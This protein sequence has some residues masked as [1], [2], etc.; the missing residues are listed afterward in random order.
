MSGAAS[1]LIPSKDRLALELERLYGRFAGANTEIADTSI[2][3]VMVLE[4]ARPADWALLAPVWHSFVNDWKLPPPAIAVNGVDGIQ[5]WFSVSNPFSAQ[6]GHQFLDGLVAHFLPDVSVNRIGCMPMLAAETTDFQPGF[7]VIP[8][9]LSGT[10]RWSAFITRDL[11]AVFGEE[12]WVDVPPQ[13][14]QQA[15]MLSR[16][17]SMTPDQFDYVLAKLSQSHSVKIEALSLTPSTRQAPESTPSAELGPEG[18]ITPTEFLCAAMNN[19]S[20]PMS[21]RIAAASALLPYS[22]RL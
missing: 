10:D 13:R 21:E 17:G 9:N 6:I 19:T 2:T 4:V 15:D 16:L 14:D 11:A 5:L 1:F 7:L 12:P 8:R 20:L 18:Q 3:R 22:N